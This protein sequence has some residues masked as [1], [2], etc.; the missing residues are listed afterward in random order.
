MLNLARLLRAFYVTHKTK[1]GYITNPPELESLLV[2]LEKKFEY[3]PD[4]VP[5]LIHQTPS[6]HNSDEFWVNLLCAYLQHPSCYPFVKKL[7]EFEAANDARQQYKH[8]PDRSIH[9]KVAKFDKTSSQNPAQ[10]LTYKFFYTREDFLIPISIIMKGFEQ[11]FREKHPSKG[12]QL[13]KEIDIFDIVLRKKRILLLNYYREIKK[14][15][16]GNVVKVIN[17]QY[18]VNK[19]TFK[20]F[21]QILGEERQKYMYG[22]FQ[23]L[24]NDISEYIKSD[25]F[26]QM[27]PEL[28]DFIK[29]Y[30]VLTNFNTS[31]NLLL[32]TPSVRHIDD[33]TNNL[34]KIFQ[35]YRSVG[36]LLPQDSYDT[37]IQ[38]VVFKYDTIGITNKDVNVHS[39]LGSFNALNQKIIELSNKDTEIEQ[40]TNPYKDLTS[41]FITFASNYTELCKFLFKL[42]KDETFATGPR[43]I[44]VHHKTISAKI[45]N[46]LIP[47]MYSDWDTVGYTQNITEGFK[48]VLGDFIYYQ[49]MKYICD[50]RRKEG[51]FINKSLMDLKTSLSTFIVQT[52]TK[53]HYKNTKIK[54]P[55]YFLGT[56]S[57]RCYERN[58]SF[59]LFSFFNDMNRKDYDTDSRGIIL[60]TIFKSNK[61][62]D[63]CFN[64]NPENT[65]LIFFTVINLNDIEEGHSFDKFPLPDDQTENIGNGTIRIT[66]NP[67]LPPYINTN[68]LKKFVNYRIYLLNIYEFMKKNSTKKDPIFQSYESV[69]EQLQ[70]SFN[71][72]K[73]EFMTHISYSPYY[74]TNTEFMENK[75]HH[76]QFLNFQPLTDANNSDDVTKQILNEIEMNNETTLI[77]TVNFSNFAEVRNS[78]NIYPICDN[79]IN[80]TDNNIFNII[81]PN[82]PEYH[83]EEKDTIN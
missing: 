8:H 58:L 75:I 41:R 62:N 36:I 55:Y 43:L 31:V 67:P 48:K 16:N 37:M 74:H 56:S 22:S 4:G 76:S 51:Y 53:K 54:L 7:K 40:V 69:R 57:E 47:V 34:F 14:D 15:E 12:I 24:L 6:Q 44:T 17:H 70:Q 77:G 25:M 65:K 83:E 71:N 23:H 61:N 81:Y 28:F 52:L 64:L 38:N 9:T 42:S 32:E 63:R 68:L 30:Y 19:Y 59:N 49:I 73:A 11:D 35:N 46:R 20:D 66:N 21:V 18:D 26:K 82:E 10:I 27:C 72:A 78:N 29:D 39:H 33:N 13:K 79:V 5:S 80:F 50:L 60:D 1:F 45:N 2:L 3:D